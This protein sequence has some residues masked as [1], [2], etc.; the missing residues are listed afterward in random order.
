MKL[1][2]V[3]SICLVLLLCES[4]KGSPADAADGINIL[5]VDVNP[6]KSAVW[7]TFLNAFHGLMTAL[8]GETTTESPTMGK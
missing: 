3:I 1:I 6:S 7:R 2:T 4:V 5:S 8:D